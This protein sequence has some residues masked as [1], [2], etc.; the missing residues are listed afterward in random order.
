MRVLVSE[1]WSYDLL[2]EEDGHLVLIVVCGSV[3]LYELALRLDD[4][5]RREWQS[6]GVNFVRSL[7]RRVSDG[8]EALVGRCTSWRWG[9]PNSSPPLQ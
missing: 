9:P 2:E 8:D 4:D 1:P 5:E 6:S 3:G 7:A